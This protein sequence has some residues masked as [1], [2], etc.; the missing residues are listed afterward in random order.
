MRNVQISLD[1]GEDSQRPKRTS[2]FYY[3]GNKTA[4]QK[5]NKQF[6]RDKVDAS[7]NIPQRAA[8]QIPK[9]PPLP[10]DVEKKKKKFPKRPLRRILIYFAIM[11][12]Y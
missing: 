7:R 12:F 10:R 4:L 1:D 11:Q 8:G 6:Y 3:A 5:R 2:E 9:I